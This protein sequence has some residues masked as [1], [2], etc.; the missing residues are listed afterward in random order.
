MQNRGLFH[1]WKREHKST[2]FNVDGYCDHCKTVLEEMGCYCHFCFCRESRAFLADQDSEQGNMNRDEVGEEKEPIYV[3]DH[4]G[5]CQNIFSNK[6]FENLL[7][8]LSFLISY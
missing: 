3:L 5:G 2:F 7:F 1:I 8:F 4:A 6:S